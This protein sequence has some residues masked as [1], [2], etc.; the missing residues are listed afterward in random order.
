MWPC[1]F[2]TNSDHCNGNSKQCACSCYLML[3]MRAITSSNHPSPHP[4]AITAI[5]WLRYRH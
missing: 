3:I 1:A 4:L 2:Y 5:I